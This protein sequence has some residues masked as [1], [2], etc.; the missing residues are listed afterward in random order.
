MLIMVS[1]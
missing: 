1:F